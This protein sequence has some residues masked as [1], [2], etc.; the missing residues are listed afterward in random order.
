M[1]TRLCAVSKFGNHTRTCVTRFGNTAGLT[2]PVA[3]PTFRV[4]TSSADGFLFNSAT[5]FL[6]VGAAPTHTITCKFHA[7]YKFLP[8][9][10]PFSDRAVCADFRDGTPRAPASKW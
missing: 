8:L 5:T 4:E 7:R 9:C 1:G 10:L 3:I 6:P 2:I